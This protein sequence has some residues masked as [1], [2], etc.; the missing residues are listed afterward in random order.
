MPSELIKHTYLMVPATKQ[1]MY[2]V[3]LVSQPNM[4]RLYQ[5]GN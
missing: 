2:A 1:M 5:L 3:R 4:Q